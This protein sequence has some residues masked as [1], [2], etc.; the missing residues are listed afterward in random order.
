MNKKTETDTLK[1]ELASLKARVTLLEKERPGRKALP[2]VVSEEHVCGVEPIAILRPAT[3][4]R[5]IAA[6]RDAWATHA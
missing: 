5:C 1:L 3:M 2:I 6:R 4:P